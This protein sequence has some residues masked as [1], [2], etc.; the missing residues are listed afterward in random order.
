[1]NKKHEQQSKNP[2]ELHKDQAFF[3]ILFPVLITVFI[4][5]LV[6]VLL[7]ISNSSDQ[8]TT[9]QWA[10]ISV[11]FL[12]LPA[13]FCGLILLILFILLIYMTGTWNKKLPT[14]LRNIRI[15]IIGFFQKVQSAAQK[16]ATPMIFIKS[17]FSGV[18]S[19][20]I[21]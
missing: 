8:Q 12:I 21:K 20:F 10:N 17:I 14:P 7:M 6:F 16:S 19:L 3:H 9:A 2:E 4:C 1:M 5:L 11:M 18:K 13:V 15:A